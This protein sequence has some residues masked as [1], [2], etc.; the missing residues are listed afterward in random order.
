VYAHEIKA[1][2]DSDGVMHTDIELTDEQK[3]LKHFIT[4]HR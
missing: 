4:A 2:A 3:T 1:Y